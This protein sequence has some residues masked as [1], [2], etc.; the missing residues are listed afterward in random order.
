MSLVAAKPLLIPPQPF[1]A[2]PTSPQLLIVGHHNFQDLDI[3]HLK[4][5]LPIQY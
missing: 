1:T 5:L 2:L 3:Q 4:K